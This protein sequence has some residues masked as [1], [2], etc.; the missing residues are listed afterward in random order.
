MLNFGCA[1]WGRVVVKLGVRVSRI[2]G[3]LWGIGEHV[4]VKI[5]GKRG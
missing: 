4:G 1:L 5:N 2:L 3:C